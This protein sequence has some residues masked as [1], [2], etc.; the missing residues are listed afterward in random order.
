T[1]ASLAADLRPEVSR[2]LQVREGATGP[3]VFEFA[4]VRVW[5]V[6]HHKPGPPTSWVLI[7]RSLGESPEWKYYV[8]NG[9]AGTPLTMLALVACSRFRVE[10]FFEEAKSYLGMVQYE[11]R[12]WIGWHHHMTLAGLAHLLVNL[13]RK[14]LKKVTGVETGSDGPSL[15]GRL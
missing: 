8:S 2:C 12:T 10:E 15:E 11:A 14:A 13:A 7:R 9:T 1:V 3:L 5:A 6:R 4:A